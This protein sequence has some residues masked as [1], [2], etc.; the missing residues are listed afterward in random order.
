MF[1]GPQVSRYEFGGNF[2]A[3]W[4]SRAWAFFCCRFWAW[5]GGQGEGLR[6]KVKVKVFALPTILDLRMLKTNKQNRSAC[7]TPRT[8]QHP[9]LYSVNP[10]VSFFSTD[11][12]DACS[13]FLA[14]KFHVEL[15]RN[16]LLGSDPKGAL[17]EVWDSMDGLFYEVCTS[18]VGL[19][20]HNY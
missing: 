17:L 8:G 2:V 18:K 5:F 3:T 7:L 11:G 14:S 13:K 19:R 20:P 15:A 12:G 16:A 4:R 9:Y 1:G 10:N 6:F